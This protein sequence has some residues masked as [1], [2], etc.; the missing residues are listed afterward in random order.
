[1]SRRKRRQRPGAECAA[2][3]GTYRPI[4]DRASCEGKG[5]CVKVCPVEVFEVRRI[6][7]ADFARLG[8]FAR[9]RSS[10]HGRLTAYTPNQDACQACGLCV[11]ACPEDAIALERIG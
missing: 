7:E 4:V 1:M 2:P 8:W 11:M 3:P 10:L 9:L 5:E 6:D